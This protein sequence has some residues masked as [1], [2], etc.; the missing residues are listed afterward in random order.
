MKR[1]INFNQSTLLHICFTTVFFFNCMTTCNSL[2]SPIKDWPFRFS[3]SPVTQCMVPSVQLTTN[4]SNLTIK[5]DVPHSEGFYITFSVQGLE[6]YNS[7]V[8]I[9][10]IL[11]IS[12]WFC[13]EISVQKVPINFVQLAWD[14]LYYILMKERREHCIFFILRASLPLSGSLCHIPD[15]LENSWNKRRKKGGCSL[16]TTH[17]MATDHKA[18]GLTIHLKEKTR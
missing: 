8:K 12:S 14:I 6:T 4:Y 5:A 1:N 11:E 13:R 3:S 2:F 18:K 17:H 16:I 9:H 7:F 10:A 15:S